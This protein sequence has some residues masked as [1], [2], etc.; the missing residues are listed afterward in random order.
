[1]S[2]RS[3]L[4]RVR[5]LGSSKEGSGHYWFQSLSAMMLVPLSIWFLSQV[6][7]LSAGTTYAE[8]LA[9][10]KIPGNTALLVLLLSLIFFHGQLGL[11]VIVEDYIHNRLIKTTTIIVIQLLSLIFVIFAIVSVL[12][13]AFVGG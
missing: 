8:F 3:P 4:G 2:M 5:G 7:Y 9:W 6:I 13:T 12:R 10:V 1:M 11:R